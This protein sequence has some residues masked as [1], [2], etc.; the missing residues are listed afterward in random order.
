MYLNKYMNILKPVKLAT[1]S[2]FTKIALTFIQLLIL[3][4][5]LSTDDFGLLAIVGVITVVTN[6]FADLG[7]NSAI[8]QQKELSQDARSSYFWI[9]IIFNVLLA[10]FIFISADLIASFYGNKELTLLIQLTSISILCLS[11]GSQIRAYEEKNLIFDRIV[12]IEI[13]SL[14][15]GFITTVS[16]AFSN[17]GVSS[18]LYGTLVTSFLSSALLWCFASRGWRPSKVIKLFE[19]R[20]GLRFSTYLIGQ[21]VISYVVISSDILFASIAFNLSQLGFYN[22]SRTLTFQ[23]QSSTFPILQ[24]VGFPVFS[25]KQ[26]NIDEVRNGYLKL[27]NISTSINSFILIGLCIFSYEITLLFFGEKWLSATE[28]ISILS[29]WSL[30]AS[31]Y[32][33]ASPVMMG[34]GKVDLIFKW[35]LFRM[36]IYAPIGLFASQYGPLVLAIALL[37]L[38][39]LLYIPAWYFVLYKPLNIKFKSFVHESI[40]PTLLSLIA[41]LAAKFCTLTFATNFLSFSVAI[42]ISVIVYFALSFQLNPKWLMY[43]A[44]FLGIKEHKKS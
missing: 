10:T 7:L 35:G 20:N 30:F 32:S 25:K 16:L 27:L 31:I 4:R 39:L 17:Y 40:L 6:L 38:S 9:N 44:N 21:R 37:S 5:L 15:F 22:L 41:W 33:I 3:A 36:I 29:V 19:I 42:T 24:R 14:I 43:L 1:I 23:I 26:E 12:K 13:I 11:V 34:I 28:L 8:I 2:T 18:V